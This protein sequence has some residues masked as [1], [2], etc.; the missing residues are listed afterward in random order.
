MTEDNLP[1][2][3]IDEVDPAPKE[4]EQTPPSQLGMLHPISDEASGE[5]DPW[6]NIARQ[7]AQ[8]AG[9]E[10]DTSLTDVL[11][12]SYVPNQYVTA[13]TPPLK[14]FALKGLTR[15]LVGLHHSMKEH[16]L[17]LE[18]QGLD[19]IDQE[20]LDTMTAQQKQAV[21]WNRNYS[22]LWQGRYWQDFDKSGDWH[23]R[24]LHNDTLLGTGRISVAKMSDPVMQIRSHMGQGTVIQIPLWHT[25]I[26]ITLSAPQNNDLHDLDAQVKLEKRELGRSTNGMIFSSVEV[27]TVAAYARFALRHVLTTTYP[28]QT[29]ETVEELM[30]V[31]KS[32]DYPQLMYG[33]LSAMY[34]EGYPFRQPCVADP[35]K[36]SHVDETILNIARL[37]WTDRARLTAMQKRL[38][39]N[40]L[41]KI[42]LENLKAYQDDFG[43]DNRAIE[44]REGVK[45]YLAVPTLM[46]Q[47]AAGF[48]WV[49]GITEA[50]NAAFAKSMSEVDRY[51]HIMNS[52][53]VT[54]LRQHSHWISKIEMERPDLPVPIVIEDVVKKDELLTAWSGDNRI[55][56]LLDDEITKWI[57]NVTVT[58]IGLP[59]SNCPACQ[60]EPSPEVT[61]HPHLI[62]LDVS[63]IFFTVV[64]LKLLQIE[65]RATGE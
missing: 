29:A 59:R 44:I 57:D 8:E 62:P 6:A 11:A 41:N 39:A 26:W 23:Q 61:Q 58:V 31:I 65:S 24:V 33:L 38:M 56:K 40:R 5:D 15:S 63:Y 7:A 22:A 27:F 16:Q 45:A 14:R 52:G 46:E 53:V 55:V 20:K 54:S 3:E 28:L 51:R 42:T 25:G 64:A 60:K 37:S 47:I 12:E 21:L 49:E 35:N 48:M 13:E 9:D 2:V 1:P 19:R 34:P 10:E 17:L 30:G 32:T 4:L 18:L 50:T 36:C 43:W